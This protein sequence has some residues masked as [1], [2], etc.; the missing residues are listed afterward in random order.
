MSDNP[1]KRRGPKRGKRHD[2]PTRGFRIKRGPSTPKK[3][4]IPCRRTVAVRLRYGGNV[5]V[6]ECGDQELDMGVW[7]V[8]KHNEVTR[9]GMVTSMPVRW[10][11]LSPAYLPA[12]REFL[13]VAT[14]DDLSRQ[15]ENQLLEREQFEFC[16]SRIKKLSLPMK[17]VTAEITFDNYKSIFYYTSDERVDFRQLVKDLV[18]RLRTRV[19][20]RQI[21]VRHEALM[22]GGMGMCGRQL[23]CSSFLKNF[24]PVSVRMAKEQRLSINTVKISGVCG[25]LM[26]CLAFETPGAGPGQKDR[27]GPSGPMGE[28]GPPPYDADCDDESALAQA[29]CAGQACGGFHPMLKADIWAKYRETGVVDDSYDWILEDDDDDEAHDAHEADDAHDADDSQD[30]HEPDEAHEA[31][32]A[33]DAEPS[34]PPEVDAAN[35][36]ESA[37]AVEGA[38]KD[39]ITILDA[40]GYLG[41]ADVKAEPNDPAGSGILA[42]EMAPAEAVA[43]PESMTYLEGGSLLGADG[44]TGGDV[45][46][47][48]PMEPDQAEDADGPGPENDADGPGPENDAAGQDPEKES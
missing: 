37:D 44:A 24:T 10:E 32:E 15:A 26:C 17:L 13:R 47:G 3:A 12:D 46:E 28:G 20:M 22:L 14:I 5:Q 30:A 48:S 39:T 42:S 1:D 45:A 4:D 6:F 40:N 23:C 27:L 41:T 19:E 11:G 25:R 36:K 35:D 16:H 29:D 8:V 21:S 33:H 9:I 31:D 34:S 38:A 43:A 7:V 2:G 18:R